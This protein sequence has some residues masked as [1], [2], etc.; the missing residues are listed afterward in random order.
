EIL[1]VPRIGVRDDFFDLGGHS[2]AATRAIARANAALDARVPLRALFD[3]P[4]V[5][6][7]ARAFAPVASGEAQARRRRLLELRLARSRG[8]APGT[9]AAFP[10]ATASSVAAPD[11][12]A[13]DADGAAPLSWAQQALWFVDRLAGPS[14]T[15]NI[16]MSA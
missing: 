13:S 9:A 15:Y 5:E 3:A 12:A 7:L 14:G 2:L 4:T 8:V 1:D 11:V 16:A 10:T 6:E